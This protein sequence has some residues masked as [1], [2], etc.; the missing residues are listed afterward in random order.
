MVKILLF[1]TG[2]NSVSSVNLSQTDGKLRENSTFYTR[3]PNFDLIRY[4]KLP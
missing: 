1:E 2:S 3:F 4:Y